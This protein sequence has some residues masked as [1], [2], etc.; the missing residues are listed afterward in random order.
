VA[1]E[2]VRRLGDGRYSIDMNRI[3]V[4][5]GGALGDFMLTLPAIGAL[6]AANPDGEIEVLGYKHIVELANNRFY[7]NEVRSIES[8]ALSR[9]FAKDSELPT[10]LKNYFASFD[11]VISYLFDP[12]QIFETNLH[13]CGLQHFVRGPAKITAGEHASRQLVRPLEQLGLSVSTLAA[14]V[15]SSAD[16]RQVARDFLANCMRPIIALHPGSGSEKK[17]WPLENW[18]RV[19]NRLLGSIDFRGAVVIIGGEA[20]TIKTNQLR[21]IWNDSRVRFAENMKLSHLAAVLEDAIFIG[22]DSG[23]SHLAAAAGAKCILLFGPTDPAV[24]AP[25]GE[26]VQ[27]IRAPNGDFGRLDAEVVSNAVGAMLRA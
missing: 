14:K 7:V 3:L 20:D 18:I 19:G 10:D 24:W 9:F 13:R 2:L 5:R 6:R 15:Y 16:D 22:H 1:N 23:I 4:I 8:A 26:N 25:A 11:L 12:D 21:S 27:V 17:N